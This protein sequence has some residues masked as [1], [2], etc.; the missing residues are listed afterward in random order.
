MFRWDKIILLLLSLVV[1]VN[2][3]LADDTGVFYLNW[4][5]MTNASQLNT[6]IVPN[7]Q[8]P[9]LTNTLTLTTQNI[10]SGT[11]SDARLSANVILANALNFFSGLWNHFQGINATE[12]N[13][14]TLRVSGARVSSLDNKILSDWSN[15]TNP[16]IIYNVTTTTCSGTDKF[17][18]FNNQTGAFVCSADSTGSET[19]NDPSVGIVTANSWAVGNGTGLNANVSIPTCSGNDKVTCNGATCSCATDQTGSGTP[20][21]YRTVLTDVITNSSTVYNVTSLG[22]PVTSG[23]NY[24]LDCSL[25]Y[26]S[27]VATTGMTLAINTSITS[28]NVVISFDTWSSATAKVTV[29]GT[30]F[31]SNLI[32]TGSGA[33]LIHQNRLVA[34]FGAMSTGN[35]NISTRSEVVAS[36]MTLKR[37]SYC[38]LLEI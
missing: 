32:G 11:F 10:T 2:T 16:P 36:V 31:N 33:T 25:L 14:T 9:T 8:M 3:S 5:R 26:T 1:T 38:M 23:K 37:G 17:S 29:S 35:I 22:F 12:I 7:A 6:G 20:P 19:E 27:A 30:T 4:T 21:I 18:S 28:N 15:I 24:T 34:G 13:V